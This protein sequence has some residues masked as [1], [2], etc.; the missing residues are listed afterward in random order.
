MSSPHGGSFQIMPEV[1]LR[2]EGG[3][4]GGCGMG[5]RDLLR[6]GKGG[7]GGWMLGC[8]ED[9]RGWEPCI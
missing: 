4:E 5:G 3:S 6:S 1:P 8:I 2:R 9:G 7:T